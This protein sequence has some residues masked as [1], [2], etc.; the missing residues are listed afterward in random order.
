MPRRCAIAALA[1]LG[2][3]ACGRVEY[4]TRYIP[5]ASELTWEEDYKQ[6]PWR[7]PSLGESHY[8]RRNRDA[9]PR[10]PYETKHDQERPV[11]GYR[12]AGDRKEGDSGQ[13]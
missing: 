3:T 12:Y 11:D 8:E 10:W 6:L 5:R 1:L 4:Q 13:Q 7:P 9:R 2:L